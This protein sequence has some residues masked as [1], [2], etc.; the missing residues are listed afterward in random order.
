MV[1]V[2][3]DHIVIAQDGWT[4]LHFACEGGHWG[5]IQYLLEKKLSLDD[6]D[7]VCCYFSRT[8]IY[9]DVC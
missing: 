1:I 7:K 3:T 8:I 5:T 9:I 4:T 6:K 2:T